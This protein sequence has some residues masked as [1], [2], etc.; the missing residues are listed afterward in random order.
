[1]QNK[2]KS[3]LDLLEEKIEAYGF[4]S[5]RRSEQWFYAACWF[6]PETN[7]NGVHGYFFDQ[8]GEHCKLALKGF[9]NIGARQTAGLLQRAIFLFPGGNVPADHPERQVALGDLGEDVEWGLLSRLTDELFSL[10]GDVAELA[11]RYVAAHP[12]EFPTLAVKI[13]NLRKSEGR[14]PRASQ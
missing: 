3:G 2:N 12:D 7:S 10:K 4:E 5:L 14:T 13:E 8:A 6:I 11:E 1:M 9:R